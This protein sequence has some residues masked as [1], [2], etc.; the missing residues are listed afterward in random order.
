MGVMKPND[1]IIVPAN[2]YIASMLA[3]SE[4]GLVPVLVEPALDSYQIDD[5]LIE[6]AITPK[7]KGI[8]IVH[9]YGQCAYTEKI[10]E[11]C[12]K[13]SLKLIEDNAQA[14]D[15]SVY[16]SIGKDKIY[17]TFYLK[18]MDF[19]RVYRLPYVSASE[20]Y[21]CI[22]RYHCKRAFDALGLNRNNIICRDLLRLVLKLN[23]FKRM[24]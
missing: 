15:T 2:T 8:L 21:H 24:C 22:Y 19:D 23:P 12:K 7:T 1:E 17:N 9:L 11:L 20:R 5:N 16:A 13:Y 10:G 3:I 6:K 14:H 18:L 4:N